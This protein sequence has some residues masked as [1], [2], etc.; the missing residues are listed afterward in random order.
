MTL[1]IPLRTEFCRTY[2]TINRSKILSWCLTSD[3]TIP[4]WLDHRKWFYLRCTP[5][6]PRDFWGPGRFP[7]LHKCSRSA[8][9]HSLSFLSWF[10]QV[11][12]CC[13]QFLGEIRPLSP[14]FLRRHEPF[15]GSLCAAKFPVLRSVRFDL[16]FMQRWGKCPLFPSQT[17][18]FKAQLLLRST[19]SFFPQLEVES[20]SYPCWSWKSALWEIITSSCFLG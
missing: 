5:P 14:V 19:T 6:S 9:E 18:L 3:I 20:V 17:T 16:D 8:A 15:P 10:P 12:S 7:S 2:M 1:K 11:R 13:L 4:P